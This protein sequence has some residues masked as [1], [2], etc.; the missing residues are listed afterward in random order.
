MMVMARRAIAEVVGL[1]L[2]VQCT[3]SVKFGIYAHPP[4]AVHSFQIAGGGGREGE[5][6]GV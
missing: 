4:R 2:L 3:C 6:V 1:A 5:G